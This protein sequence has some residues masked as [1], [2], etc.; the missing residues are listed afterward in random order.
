MCT[1]GAINRA[2]NATLSAAAAGPRQVDTETITPIGLWPIRMR[3]SPIMGRLCCPDWVYFCFSSSPHEHMNTNLT[4]TS[5]PSGT[6]PESIQEILDQGFQTM[7]HWM[8]HIDELWVLLARSLMDAEVE[9]LCGARYQRNAPNEGRYKRWGSNPGS[10]KYFGSRIPIRV[11]RV[12][13]TKEGRERPLASYQQMHRPCAQ[14][15]DLLAKR[16]IRGLSQRDYKKTARLFAE[17]LGLSAS[18]IS[19]RFIKRSQAALKAYET[20]RLDTSNY[21][22]LLIDGK[23]MGEVQIILCMGITATGEKHVLGFVE[24]QTEN[25]VAIEGLL[26]DLLDRGLCVDEGILCVIDGAKGLPKAIKNVLGPKA[27]VQRCVQ[28]KRENVLSKLTKEEDKTRV[29][30]Q[31]NEAYQECSY[32]KAKEK[33]L[34]LQATLETDHNDAANS[35]NEGME[36]T[37]TLHRLKIKGSLRSHLQTTNIIENLNSTLRRRWHRVTRWRN[38]DQRHRWV[39]MAIQTAEQGFTAIPCAEQLPKLQNAL[40]RRVQKHYLSNAGP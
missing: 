9:H 12:R 14:D 24:T 23:N 5:G 37:L 38:S 19:R 32:T 17:G 8:T 10:L 26:Q 18:T 7:M 34:A 36:E 28:H 11:Q 16:V 13:D 27:Q 21:V 2:T 35:L 30:R 31:M 3:Y 39:A 1:P 25:A 29:R 4:Y 20:R 15:Q 33:L 6:H 22:A 40:S